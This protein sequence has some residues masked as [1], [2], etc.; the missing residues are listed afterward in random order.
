MK[1]FVGLSSSDKFQVKITLTD[2]D[3]INQSQSILVSARAL[4]EKY[5]ILISNYAS[6]E[7]YILCT[8]TEFM[9]H[10]GLN[11]SNFFDLRHRF[12]IQMVN[13]LTSARLYIDQVN[14]DVKNSVPNQKD[15]DKKIDVL[16]SQE[17]DSN[18]DYQFMEALRNYVQHCGLA[19]HLTNY[20]L[21]KKKNKTEDS[22]EYILSFYA[23]KS[24][25]KKDNRFKSSVLDGYNDNIDLKASVRGY[26]ESLSKI[27]ASVREMIKQSVNEARAVLTQYHKKYRKDGKNKIS[28]LSA[29]KKGG[30]GEVISIPLILDWDDSRI[31]LIKRNTVLI[32]LKKRYISS[33]V[34]D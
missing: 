29:F 28:G 19:V 6:L 3:T 14:R 18:H 27:H 33:I 21:S 30:N 23:I 9:L 7:N 2:F 17:Y 5:D 34:K 25:L 4:E 31:D 15:I 24:F 1:Y 32:N 10:K 12:N 20:N 16:K 22:F 26:I 11:Y 13:L 8:T